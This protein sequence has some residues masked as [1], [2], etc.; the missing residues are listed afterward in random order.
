MSLR[1][2]TPTRRA[3]AVAA[4]CVAM[5]VGLTACGAGQ[6]PL[7]SRVK[8]ATQGLNVD[9]GSVK[10]LDAAIVLDTPLATGATSASAHLRAVFLNTGGLQDKIT[11]IG[12]SAASKVTITVGATSAIEVPLPSNKPANFAL[13]D[14]RIELESISP[15]PLP[16]SL[17]PVTISF[18]LAGDLSISLPVLSPDAA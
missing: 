17:L 12:S 15:S 2:M 9:K 8:T 13:G 7:T 4:T 3:V 1:P 11:A 10:I 5:A 6:T 14:N 18:A 16:G